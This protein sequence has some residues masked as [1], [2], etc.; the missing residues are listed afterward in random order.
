[1]A[2]TLLANTV[3]AAENAI[4]L[5]YHRVGDGRYP[6]T[7]IDLNQFQAQLAYLKEERYHVWPM[8]KIINYLSDAKALPEKTVGI[9]FDDAYQS[10]YDNAWP[11]LKKY[12]YPFSLMV[13]TYPVDQRFRDMMTW[14]EIKILHESGVLIGNHSDK[15][16]HMTTL[17]EAAMK[18][19][20]KRAEESFKI[21]L[22]FK[23]TLFAYPYGEY[24]NRLRAIVK[25]M[26]FKAA[27]GQQSSVAWK[28]SDKWSYPRF[29]LNKH[30]GDIARFKM[31]TSLL[32]LPMKD[33][34][35]SAVYYSNPPRLHLTK[36]TKAFPWE[37]LHCYDANGVAL[38]IK[39][40]EEELFV[41][42]NQRF[43]AGRARVNCTLLTKEGQ[44]YWFGKEFLV[45]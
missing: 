34:E 18:E 45:E 22:D 41:I 9:S 37:R 43:L 27:F 16:A 33:K 23:P 20:I 42:P 26:G 5:M 35:P 2:G 31:V 24:D 29:A 7:N 8:D 44:W 40:T 25:D 38:P 6:S 1:M 30:Y 14:E 36:L 19:D 32:P 3:Y 10:I 13:A 39:K 4:L 21:H 12:G 11:L 28:Y 17:T 15:H